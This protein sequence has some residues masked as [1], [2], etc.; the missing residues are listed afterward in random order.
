MQKPDFQDG[1]RVIIAE[2]KLTKFCGIL[3]MT[4][5]GL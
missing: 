5:A 4:D 1:V 2:H 3:S